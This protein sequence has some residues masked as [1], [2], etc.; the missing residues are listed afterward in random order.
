MEHE[1]VGEPTFVIASLPYK[2]IRPNLLISMVSGRTVVTATS[3]SLN[4]ELS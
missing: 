4:Q 2:V 1:S 3:P